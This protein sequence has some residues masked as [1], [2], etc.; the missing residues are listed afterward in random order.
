MAYVCPNCPVPFCR[1]S[2]LPPRSSLL[3]LIHD[4][5]R[6]CIVGQYVGL[7]VYLSVSEVTELFVAGSVLQCA[8]LV[9]YRL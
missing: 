9:D 7:S 6:C 5:G 1:P 4:Y 2:S 8:R 3:S